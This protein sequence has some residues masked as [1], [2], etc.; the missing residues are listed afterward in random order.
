MLT[1]TTQRHDDNYKS[2]VP[3]F[4]SNV[5]S[6]FYVDDLNTGVRDANRGTSL[7]KKIL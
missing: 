4:R 2:L 5:A 1:A 7:H 3:E 6:H